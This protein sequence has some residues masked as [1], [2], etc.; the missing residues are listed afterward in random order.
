MNHSKMHLTGDSRL[1][2]SFI[3]NTNIELKDNPKIEV[4][5]LVVSN[6]FS[7]FLIVPEKLASFVKERLDNVSV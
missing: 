7:Q 5:R 1:P 2:N 6:L 3:I 4:K